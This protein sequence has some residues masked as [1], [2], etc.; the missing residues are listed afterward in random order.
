MEINTTKSALLELSSHREKEVMKIKYYINREREES[1]GAEGQGQACPGWDCWRRTP[2]GWSWNHPK[3]G[4]TIP[5]AEGIAST[6]IL[7]WAGICRGKHSKQ[8]A[9][10]E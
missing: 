1:R 8:E 3:V 7:G 5:P 6:F 4:R 2:P 9:E 10:K